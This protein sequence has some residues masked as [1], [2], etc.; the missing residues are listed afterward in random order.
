MTYRDRIERRNE[1]KNIG[2][3]LL[4][5]TGLAILVYSFL[6]GLIFLMGLVE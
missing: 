6:G 1:W 3:G 5:I 4:T 2:K